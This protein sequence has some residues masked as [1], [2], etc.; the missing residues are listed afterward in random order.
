MSLLLRYKGTRKH[1]EVKYQEWYNDIVKKGKADNFEVISNW[2]IVQVLT[3][4]FGV[5]IKYEITEIKFAKLIQEQSPSDFRYVPLNIKKRLNKDY[6]LSR[7]F[8]RIRILSFAAS[9]L[10]NNSNKRITMKTLRHALFIS[11]AIIG[12]PFTMSKLDGWSSQKLTPMETKTPTIL[13]S[14]VGNKE[15]DTAIHI[16]VIINVDTTKCKIDMIK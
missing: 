4:I 8:R 5:W 9:I 12:L 15:I 6:K 11:I 14:F 3:R 16:P 1:K 10:N 13:D 7:F 2:D